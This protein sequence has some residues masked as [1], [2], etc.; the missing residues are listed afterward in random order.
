MIEIILKAKKQLHEIG[1]CSFNLKDFDEQLFDLV[2]KCRVTN[3]EIEKKNVTSL[4]VDFENYEHPIDG[5]FEN[6]KTFEQAELKKIEILKNCKEDNIFQIWYFNGT[7]MN[8]KEWKLIPVYDKITKYFYDLDDNIDLHFN[9]QFTMYDKDCFLKNHNDGITP[10]RICVVLVYLNE[11]YDF[12]NGGILIIDN[13]EKI[14]PELGTISVL[15]LSKFNSSHEVTKVTGNK[16]RYTALS[17][18]SYKKKQDG[19]K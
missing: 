14:I 2:F 4:R 1:Y 10:G 7:K 8:T 18:V 12:N 16:K 13:K 9:S 11:N 5:V 3:D 6:F 15:D 19:H 17:F